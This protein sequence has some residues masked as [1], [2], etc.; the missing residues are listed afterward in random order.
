MPT[1]NC[2]D[3][4]Y[5]PRRPQGPRRAGW[6]LL[7]L[8]MLGS[9]PA[10]ACGA[11][12]CT[13]HTDWVGQG[14]SS[15]TGL[16]LDL[17]ADLFTQD[18]LRMGSRAANRD[19]FPLP[20]EQEIQLQTRNR[21]LTATLDYTPTPDWGLTLILPYMDRWHGTTQ[22][23][24]VDPSYS[25]RHGLG[26]ARIM[27]RYQGFGETRN[28]GFQVGLKLPT[29]GTGQ[30][31]NGG[32]AAGLPLDAG[33]QLGTG[34]TDLLLGAFAHGAFGEDWSGFVQA[35]FQKPLAERHG[36][37]PGEGVNA[38][39]GV[40]Y[41]GWTSLV[42]HLQI[43]VRAEGRESGINGDV[44]NSGATLT[45]LS[46]GLSWPLAP[47]VQAYAFAQVPLAQRVNGL[48]L[49]PRRSLSLGLHWTW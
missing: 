15:G 41:T 34:T 37:K 2:L 8:G 27:G 10:W 47:G 11:C 16:Q 12:G 42:P 43:N 26:D 17:R 19:A 29:G 35:V 49:E 28:I 40:R 14:W 5:E 38:N 18:Q 6:L 36:F 23:G 30:A 22:E 24:D 44:A 20:S 7:A 4:F 13:L 33:L 9:S 25:D 45:Y 39:A 48:Q 46:P 3:M 32:P 31:F 1:T 21:N